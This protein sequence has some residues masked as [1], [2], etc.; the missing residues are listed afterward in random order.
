KSRADDD[1]CGLAE[2]VNVVAAIV[3]GRAERDG[4][5]AT[6]EGA[7]DV[8]RRMVS[9]A[10]TRARR[11]LVQNDE[12]AAGERAL[13]FR[14]QTVTRDE[15]LPECREQEV[16]ARLEYAA[17][18]L[19]PRVLQILGEVGHGRE[20]IEQIEGRIAVGER[21]RQVVERGLGEREMLVAPLHHLRIDVASEDA[22]AGQI[23]PVAENAS[24]PAA[25]V[26]QRVDP[27]DRGTVFS[28]DVT[29]QVGVVLSAA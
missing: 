6:C 8:L 13:F 5:E 24:A 29:D 3:G 2:Q 12:V 15:V 14:G 18:F 23:G 28:E 4:F 27:V 10:E 11:S 21:W 1:S 22:R 16:S 20:R 19:H 9:A 26:E 7:A 17:T 25:P